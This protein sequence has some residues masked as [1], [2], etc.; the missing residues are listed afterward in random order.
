MQAET[1]TAEPRVLLIEDDGDYAYILRRMLTRRGGSALPIEHVDRLAAGISRMDEGGIDAVLLDLDLPDSFG[2]ET[3]HAVNRRMPEVPVVVL[4][5]HDDERVALKAV[6]DGAQDYLVKGDFD[7]RLLV[8][9]IRYAIERNHLQQTLRNL[10]LEDDL[11]GLYNRRGFKALAEQQIRMAYR[12]E[13]CLL[14]IFA[15]LDG[16]KAINDAHG[17]LVGSEAIVDTAK[18]LLEN[19]RDS[20]IVARLGGDEFV[21]LLPETPEKDFPVPANRLRRR[22]AE[23]NRAAGRPYQ[24][25]L[26]LGAAAYDPRSPSPLDQLI[27]RADQAM[28]RDKRK[29]RRAREQAS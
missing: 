13:T 11:T 20:D 6:R 7:R 26:S 12:Q 3:F 24:L 23:F 25:S 4:S 1:K 19:F 9:A 16:L 10:S 17:H 8:R 29:R 18:L 28:Y 5:G 15:D 14:L 2:I 27:E 22:L 21:V